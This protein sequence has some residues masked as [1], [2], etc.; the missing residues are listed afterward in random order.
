MQVVTGVMVAFRCFA[1]AFICVIS[2]P[3]RADI[4][5]EL[6]PAGAACSKLKLISGGQ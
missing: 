5:L 4:Q 3:V 2:W 6:C 1:L